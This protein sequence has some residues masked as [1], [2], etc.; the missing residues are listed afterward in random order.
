M[1]GCGSGETRH[2]VPDAPRARSYSKKLKGTVARFPSY[3]CV[4]NRTM[5]VEIGN[6]PSRGISKH[7][8]EC[9][10]MAKFTRDLQSRATW[11]GM[12]D[13]WRRCAENSQTSKFLGAPEETGTKFRFAASL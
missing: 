10:I 6:A 3:A 4:R 9:E 11:M 8:G 7:A 13:R 5:A 1:A 12:V 2:K